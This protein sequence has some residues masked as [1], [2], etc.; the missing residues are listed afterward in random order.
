M[1][2]IINV[3]ELFATP[4][5]SEEIEILEKPKHAGVGQKI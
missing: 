2:G 4:R 3:E 5:S 1:S